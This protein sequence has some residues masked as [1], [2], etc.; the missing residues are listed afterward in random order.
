[1]P[2]CPSCG[3]DVPENAGFCGYCGASSAGPAPEAGVPTTGPRPTITYW[4]CSRCSVESSSDAQ[5]CNS[6]GSAKADPA[7]AAV[8]MPT[9]ALPPARAPAG[10]RPAAGHRTCARCGALNDPDSHFCKH[11]GAA[12]FAA[13]AAAAMPGAGGAADVSAAD[14]GAP[15][16]GGYPPRAGAASSSRGP[17]GH[18]LVLVAALIAVAAA[19]AAA[20]FVLLNDSGGGSTQTIAHVTQTP[21]PQTT[22]YVT[23][24][25]T[26]Q[27]TPSSASTTNGGSIEP[28]PT[29]RNVTGY[30]RVS[31]S[32]NLRPENG[33]TY[34][35]SNL[36]DGYKPTCWAEGVA[37][38][39]EYE[40]VT[41][42]FDEPM[43]LARARVIPG[44][45]KMEGTW[46]RWWS[47]GRLQRVE[48]EFSDGATEKLDFGD[49]KGW[50]EFDLGEIRTRAV[51]MTILRVFGSEP[52]PQRASDTCVSEVELWGWPESD[53]P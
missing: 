24:T 6:C 20:A 47:N 11:C 28:A 45:A 13:P 14:H 49:W 43:V 18:R 29:A 8:V 25:P 48:L 3:R 5:F 52:G 38:N 30:C 39:G 31:A 37:G 16:P 40:Y 17:R 44:Y 51:K 15:P 34:E 26:P 27:P 2:V 53:E 33:H 12:G 41:F 23:Q 1:M 46:D 10:P 21:T 4:T 19:A 50:Q 35:A 7:A 36:V 32:S 9:A 42:V 22:V